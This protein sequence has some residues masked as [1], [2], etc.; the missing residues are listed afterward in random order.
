[1]KYVQIEKQGRIAVVRFDRGFAANALSLELMRELTQ[2]ARSFDDDFET[3]AVILTGRSDNFTMGF[4]LK[5]AENTAQRD[6]GLA[7]RRLGLMTGTRM[8]KA[9]EDVQA[10][11]ISAIVRTPISPPDRSHNRKANESILRTQHRRRRGGSFR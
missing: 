2:A 9:W 10:L 5:D 4:D 6:A 1:M 3:S 11:T 8:C 7:E